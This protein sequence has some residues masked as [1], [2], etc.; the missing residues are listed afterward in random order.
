MTKKSRQKFLALKW[1]FFPKN[2]IRKFV[3]IKNVSVSPKLGAKSPPIAHAGMNE[4]RSLHDEA[5][6]ATASEG[7]SQGSYVTRAGCEPNPRP[8]GRKV[9]TLPMCHQVNQP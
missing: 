6:Q 4:C 8:S 9:S 5:L 3:P 1:K 2:V 7:F